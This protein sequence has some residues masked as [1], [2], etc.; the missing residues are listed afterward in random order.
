MAVETVEEDVDPP[1]RLSLQVPE[2]CQV[3]VSFDVLWKEEKEDL[4]PFLKALVVRMQEELAAPRKTI[5]EYV[6]SHDA[7]IQSLNAQYRGKD[8]PT[9][10]L[11][12]PL[13]SQD[14]DSPPLLGTIVLAYETIHR[15]AKEQQKSFSH[16]SKHLI[17]HGALHLLGLTHETS[18]EAEVMESYERRILSTFHIPDPYKVL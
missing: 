9:N 10:V 1:D 12:F 2:A 8:A 16:H 14:E 3:D 13:A 4:C 7:H 5:F 18:E 17:V 11:S 6:F 15:E